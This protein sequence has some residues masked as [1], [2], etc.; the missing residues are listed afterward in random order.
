[1]KHIPRTSQKQTAPPMT[2]SAAAAKAEYLKKYLEPV[3]KKRRKKPSDVAVPA[4]PKKTGMKIVDNDFV[5]PLKSLMEKEEEGDFMPVVVEE[6]DEQKMAAEKAKATADWVVIQDDGGAILSRGAEASDWDDIKSEEDNSPPRRRHDTPSPTLSPPR[7]A[8]HDTPSPT[9]SPPRRRPVA[10]PSPPRRQRH[11]S[12]SPPRRGA[13]SAVI[14]AEP[15]DQSPPRKRGRSPS[16]GDLSPPRKRGGD[17]SPPRKRHASPGDLSP[18]RKGGGDLSPPRKRGRADSSPPRA[19][20]VRERDPPLKEVKQEKPTSPMRLPGLKAGLSTGKEFDEHAKAV[21]KKKEEYLNKMDP[22]KMGRGAETVYR[23]RRGRKLEMLTEFMNQEEEARTGVKKDDGGM[24]MEWGKGLVQKQEVEDKMKRLEDEK[25]K[26][27][28]RS[29]EDED[30]NDHYR[31]QDRWGDP[32]ANLLEEKSSGTVAKRG[33]SKK[34]KK[35]TKKEK[36]KDKKAKLNKKNAEPQVCKFRAPPNRFNIPPG[37][38]WDGVDRSNGFEKKYF[39][40][41]SSKIVQTQ[42]AYMWSVED[43]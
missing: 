2:Q 26:P 11:D 10:S 7:R 29:I 20:K 35:K 9:S 12:P 23:D 42:Q 17:L 41:Q 25:S 3:K 14:K 40:K 19:P 31:A 27:F 1:V 5:A 34:E 32:M 39:Q 24:V 15:S 36:K 21:K 37:P 33:K 6:I 16:N 4:K 22:E 8:R 30:L 13:L 18:P 43:M 28:A 38:Y